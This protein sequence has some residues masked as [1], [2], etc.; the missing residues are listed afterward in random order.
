MF[1]VVRKSHICS[2]ILALILVLGVAMTLPGGDAAE[3]VS[4]SSGIFPE[5]PVYLI[6]PGHGGEDGGAVAADGTTESAL[7]LEIALRLRDILRFCGRPTAMT[8]SEDAAIYSPGMET[9]RQK[10]ASDL[11]NRVSMAN[12]LEKGVLIS[13]HQNALPQS[14][15]VHGAQVFYN[16]VSGAEEIADRIQQQLNEVINLHKAKESKPI[17]DS[18]YLMKHTEIPAVLVECGFLSNG[19]ETILLRQAAHQ[20]KLSLAIAAGIGK[21]EGSA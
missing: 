18:I 13:I 11:K 8:R 21:E 15:S 14:P 12:Q 19:E 9:L 5:N 17:P 7:N 2:V 16:T 3:P 1:I 10:K 6:D 20:K 4:G